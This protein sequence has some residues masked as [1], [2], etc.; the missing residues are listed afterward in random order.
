MYAIAPPDFALLPVEFQT[1]TSSQ[2]GPSHAGWKDTTLPSPPLATKIRPAPS[3]RKPLSSRMLQLLRRR[4]PSGR[5]DTI[6]SSRVTSTRLSPPTATMPRGHFKLL[7]KVPTSHGA[8]VHP[9]GIACTL[10]LLLSVTSTWSPTQVTPAAK[11]DNCRGPWPGPQPPSTSEQRGVQSCPGEQF[12]HLKTP[13]APDL[14]PKT[15]KSESWHQ[16]MPPKLKD[17]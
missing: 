14:P 7:A 2:L 13:L 6:P 5:N 12:V 15:M 8:V 16:A 3:H 17:P 1:S 4:A 11:P 10:K 9:T